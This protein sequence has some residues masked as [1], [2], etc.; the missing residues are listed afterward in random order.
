[1]CSN[2]LVAI[3]NI[4]LPCL[5]RNL[6]ELIKFHLDMCLELLLL[7]H[8]LIIGLDFLTH[9]HLFLFILSCEKLLVFLCSLMRFL[10]LF[11]FVFQLSESLI[12]FGDLFL[13][14]FDL[15]LLWAD[16]NFLV[17]L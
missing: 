14:V 9:L 11:F 6:I 4:L 13:Y 10:D 8:E 1:L 5:F 15:L 17:F 12:L 2:E 7:F 16:D 3:L